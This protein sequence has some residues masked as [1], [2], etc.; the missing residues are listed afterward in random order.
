MDAFGGSQPPA[1]WSSFIQVRMEPL[2]VVASANE[3]AGERLH[4]TDGR[5]PSPKGEGVRRIARA[6][7]AMGNINSLGV[8]RSAVEFDPRA[9]RLAQ[10]ARDRKIRKLRMQLHTTNLEPRPHHQERERQ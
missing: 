10:L 3:R 5:T 9:V 6:R 4:L 2:L 8:K 1:T 7:R